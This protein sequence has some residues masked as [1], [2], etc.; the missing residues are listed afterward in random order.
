MKQYLVKELQSIVNSGIEKQLS[1]LTHIEPSMLYKPMI[2]SLQ[3]GGKRLRPILLLLSYN[4][5][6]DDL[7]QALPAAVSVEVFH[8]FTLL[9]DDIIDKSEIRRHL[10]SAYVKFGENNAIL[11]GDAMAFL[12]YRILN[13]CASDKVTDIMN[14][15]TATAIEVCEGQQYDIDFEDCAEI[16][17]SDYFEMI[18]LKTAVLIG[19]CLK[20]GAML[21]LADI[22]ICNQLY[23]LGISLGMAFQ[24]QDDLLDI[25]GSQELLGKKIG[26]DITGNKKNY[27]LVKAFEIAGKDIKSELAGWLLTSGQN[28]QEKI[29]AVIDIYNKLSV[30]SI[31]EN[32]IEYYFNKVFSILESLPLDKSLTVQLKNLI[33]GLQVR[34]Y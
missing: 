17:E 6:S 33:S 32:K 22:E 26:N 5:F 18:R 21:G 12:S 3:M 27:L 29:N 10:P 8:N 20:A 25:Y 4:I 30:K 13:E 28:E 11:S 24:L 19:Y 23:N 31:T 34:K 1:E 16:S 15:F 2:Y 14:L 7:S 9:H